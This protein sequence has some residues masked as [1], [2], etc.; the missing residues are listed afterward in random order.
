MEARIARFESHVEHIKNDI[1]EIKPDIR[2]ITADANS[3][4]WLLFGALIFV[5]LGLADIMAKGIGW[6]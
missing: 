1:G 5:A 4:C 3:D 2:E 6:L